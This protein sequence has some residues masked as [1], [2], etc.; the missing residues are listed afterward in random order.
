MAL[1]LPV[2]DLARR[3]LV[4]MRLHSGEI[5]RSVHLSGH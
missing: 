1:G 3:Y 5:L 2:K 4:S